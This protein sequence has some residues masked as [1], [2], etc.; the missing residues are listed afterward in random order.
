MEDPRKPPV[1]LGII[2]GTTMLGMVFTASHCGLVH[3]QQQVIKPALA[4]DLLPAIGEWTRV[5]ISH[6]EENGNYFL[7]LGIGGAEV[8]R[9]EV[10][11]P[12]LREMTNVKVNLGHP[13]RR[14]QQPGFIQRLIMLHKH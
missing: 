4:I 11:D 9:K 12:E 8:A 6:K 2:V 10:A 5:E 3:I 13:Q 1:S 7:S 14:R